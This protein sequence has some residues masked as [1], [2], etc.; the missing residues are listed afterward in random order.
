M[1]LRPVTAAWNGRREPSVRGRCCGQS[2]STAGPGAGADPDTLVFAAVP[3]EQTTSLRQNYQP[4]LDMLARETGKKVEFRQVTNYAA[5]IDGPPSLH[6]R[7]A[8]ALRSAGAD[9]APLDVQVAY[10]PEAFGATAPA[11]RV[12]R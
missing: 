3:S 7:L 6:E 5:V 12:C 1:A 4:V 11:G 10:A 2:A 9:V 8:D